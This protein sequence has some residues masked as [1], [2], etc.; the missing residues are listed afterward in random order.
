MSAAV[1]PAPAPIVVA[2]TSP[3]GPSR[4]SIILAFAAVYLVWGSTYLA[5]RWVLETL[6]PLST[7]G[8]RFIVAGA[9]L[10]A[11][12]WW[13][14]RARPGGR[15]RV[16]AR[17]WGWSTLVGG[18]L[19]LG[20]NGAVV[21]AEQRVPSGVAALLV[22]IMPCWLVLL[23]WL[24]PSRKVPSIVTVAGLLTG[25]AGL[26]LLVGL[27]SGDAPAGVDLAGTVVLLLGS[28]SWA[29]G[30]LVARG[31][32]L[33]KSHLR[34]S[35][36]QMVGGGVLLSIAGVATGEL[37][38]IDLAGVSQASALAWLYLVFV[39]SLVGFTAFAF[40][41]RTVSPAKVAT[42]A[43]VNPVVA[44]LLGWAFAGEAV[45]ARMGVAAAV[46]VAAVV[47][48]TKGRS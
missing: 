33:A 40:L 13:S 16:T 29:A 35:G 1:R 31:A 28:L 18:L 23:E 24:G 20:G 34:N 5:I 11:W 8:V 6:P 22:A 37:P 47:M 42:Y 15:E 12:A 25:T 2:A 9:V 10:L 21:W 4:A 46:I 14:E 26:A 32:P 17:Q 36:M 30:S 27:G 7:A 48:I 39:G 38:R 43:Y 19:F 41:M 45:S 3:T 44:V